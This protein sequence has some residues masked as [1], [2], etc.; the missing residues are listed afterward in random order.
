MKLQRLAAFGAATFAVI[1]LTVASATPALAHDELVNRGLEVNSATGELSALT[2]VF[3]NDI[4]AVGTEIIVT[5]DS[6]KNVASAEP[7]VAGPNVRQPLDTPLL[8][9]GY[10]TAWRVVSSDGHPIEGT[11]GI[12]ID[13][14]G[15]AKIVDSLEEALAETT[16]SNDG[17]GAAEHGAEGHQHDAVATTAAP[18]ASNMPVG[19]W[20]AIGAALVAGIAVT[21]VVIARKSKRLD[22]VG[23]SGNASGSDSVTASDNVSEGGSA[24]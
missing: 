10:Q 18:S 1:G 7:E 19:G 22:E 21:T 2:L 23:A 5:D 16:P 6:G 14:D 9:G 11:F 8:V 3:S 4:L 20:V 15:T 17:E 24:N 13:A 12:T